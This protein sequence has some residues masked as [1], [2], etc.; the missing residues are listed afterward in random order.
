MLALN[1]AATGM[2]AQTTN[3]EVIANN[4]ANS[5]TT[6]FK[7]SAAQFADLLYQ[8]ERMAGV[9]FQGTST[10]GQVPQSAQIGLGVQTIAIETLNTQGSLIQTGNQLDVALQG[11]G[12]FQVTGPNN[13]TVYTRAGNFSK[14]SSGQLVTQDGYVITP[15]ITFPTSTVDI[16]IN[17]TGAVYVDQGNPP[18][19]YTQVGQ[20]QLAVFPNDAGMQAL[21]NNLFQPTAASGTAQTGNPGSPGYATTLQYYLEQSNVDPVQ[22]ITNLINAQRNYELN[23]KVITAADEMYQVITKNNL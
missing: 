15:G 8:N 13:Q 9:P 22:E 11:R 10:N 14:N 3:V 12:W 1:I 17:A 2:A 18:G 23:S 4:V 19:T 16:Q 7:R 21:G 6:A 20:L 5:N